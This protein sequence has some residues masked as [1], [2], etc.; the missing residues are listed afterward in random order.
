M[1]LYGKDGEVLGKGKTKL[2]IMLVDLLHF[3]A[4]TYR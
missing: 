4:D 1:L 2:R 3:F